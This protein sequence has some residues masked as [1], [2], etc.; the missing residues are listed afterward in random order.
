MDLT[1]DVGN[2]QI[3]GGLFNGNK[4]VHRFRK[5]SVAGTSSDELGLFLKSAIR[6]NGFNPDEVSRI[7]CC[8]VVPAINHS[9]GSACLKYFKVDP[10]F[11]R[12]GTRTGLKIK[13]NNPKDVGADRIA[14]SI[15]GS[16]LYPDKSL[17]IID[18][19]TATTFDVV[20]ADRTYLG[21][22]IVPGIKISMLALESGTARLP[23]VEIIKPE[24]ACGTSTIENIQAGLYFG[25]VGII[26]EMVRR[27]TEECFGNNRPVVIGTG[28][29]S[30]LFEGQAVFDVI[31][32]DL[33]LQGLKVA[34]DMNPA[35][36]ES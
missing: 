20:S 2:S 9:L 12:S 5:V 25:Q 18:M 14:N 4:I 26:R 22:A 31:E 23:S 13:Y 15:G 30:R 32:P 17:I 11:L 34:L 35:E 28:G 6:E 27:L 1:I 19:G 29:F 10:F 33:V 7:G 8:S 36:V 21:G 16:S 3:L 24:K